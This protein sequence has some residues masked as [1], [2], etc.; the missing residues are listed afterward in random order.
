MKTGDTEKGKQCIQCGE[1]KKFQDISV[2]V[3]A[4]NK[5]IKFYIK[6]H[7]HSDCL[8]LTDQFNTYNKA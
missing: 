3:I 2:N 6:D 1:P 7:Q 5:S 4:S 8:W